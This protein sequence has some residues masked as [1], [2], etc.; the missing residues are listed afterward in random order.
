MEQGPHLCTEMPVTVQ[1]TA[2]TQSHLDRVNASK[3]EI[4]TRMLFLG[5]GKAVLSFV[6]AQMLE[7][8]SAQEDQRGV[9]FGPYRSIS[10]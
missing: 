1:V 8:T 5:S 2:P 9:I 6:L 4:V 7:L 10:K 3:S